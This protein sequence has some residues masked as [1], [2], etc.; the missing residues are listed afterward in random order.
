MYIADA[1]LISDTG[2]DSSIKVVVENKMVEISIRA[3]FIDK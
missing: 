3:R 2:A 1:N